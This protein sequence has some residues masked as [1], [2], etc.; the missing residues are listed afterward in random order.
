SKKFNKNEIYYYNG[1]SFFKLELFIQSLQYFEK[2]NNNSPLKSQA[3]YWTAITYEKMKAWDSAIQQYEELLNE[4]IYKAEY[5]YRLGFC[6][7]MINETN[8]AKYYYTTAIQ[9]NTMY[10]ESYLKRAYLNFNSG[11]YNNAIEDYSTVIDIDSINTPLA[12]KGIICCNLMTMNL[13]EVNKYL[14]TLIEKKPDDSF[15]IA[16][17]NFLLSNQKEDFDSKTYFQVLDSTITILPLF[18]HSN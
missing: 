2:I 10:S 17:Q 16:T 5:Y 13:D 12:I 15:I 4:G 3:L 6:H 8:K 9:T 1:L 14:L 18:S 11:L 7:E